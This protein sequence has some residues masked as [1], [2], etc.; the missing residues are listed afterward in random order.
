MKTIITSASSFRIRRR[1]EKK[2]KKKKK[3]NMTPTVVPFQGLEFRVN[4]SNN[5]LILKF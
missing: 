4:Y 2:K 1:N 5:Y 3:K